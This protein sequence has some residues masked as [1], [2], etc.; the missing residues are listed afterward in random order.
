MSAL[1]DVLIINVMCSISCF[2]WISNRFYSLMSCQWIRCSVRRLSFIALLAGIS[3]L[4]MLREGGRLSSNTRGM[5]TENHKTR[6]NQLENE[7][8]VSDWYESEAFRSSPHSTAPFPCSR[9]SLWSFHYF[10]ASKSHKFTQI[11]CVAR[12]E[13]NKKENSKEINLK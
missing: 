13:R 9:R 1:N 5:D 12:M 2:P 8:R 10:N 11:F 6:F 4:L 3:K 7:L